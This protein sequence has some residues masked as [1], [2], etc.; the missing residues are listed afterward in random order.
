MEN[1]SNSTFH[2]P[3]PRIQGEGGVPKAT[4]VSISA[5]QSSNGPV[6]WSPWSADVEPVEHLGT[7]V[8]C[9]FRAKMV[10]RLVSILVRNGFADVDDRV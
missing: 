8:N 4:A 5:C 1:N 2:L 10:D 7:T 6:I 9:E 3:R